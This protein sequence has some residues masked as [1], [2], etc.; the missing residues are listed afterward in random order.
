VAIVAV[1]L[2]GIGTHIKNQ[3][4]SAMEFFHLAVS[5]AVSEDSLDETNGNFDIE[6]FT[7]ESFLLITDERLRVDILKT[8]D[9]LL[10]NK[11]K[12]GKGQKHYKNNNEERMGKIYTGIGENGL[13]FGV[14][15]YADNVYLVLN[16]AKN[17]YIIF[18]IP[19]TVNSYAA[20]FVFGSIVL[21]LCLLYMATIRSIRPLKTLREK[22]KDFAEGNDEI[23]IETR[24]D[25]EIAA[26]INEFDVAVKKM[27]AFRQAR[28]L[29]LRNI[30]HEFKTPITRGKLSL[31]M[32]DSTS[33][34]HKILSKVFI[35]QESLLNEFTRIEQLGT[36]ELKVDKGDYF[37]RDIVDYAL[38]ILGEAAQNVQVD[39]DE[40]KIYADFDLLAT[41][42][43]NLLDNA[44]LYSG[45]K[46]ADITAKNGKM[47]ISNIG[48]PLEFPLDEYKKPFFMQGKKQ[49]ESRGLG[50]GLFISLNIF[51]LHGIETKYEYQEG[52]SIF[53]L[54]F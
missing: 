21:L 8:Y 40:Q 14:V 41:A 49:K 17:E 24:G 32:L 26:V 15:L 10:F 31:E 20:L 50:F 7:N 12:S 2:I 25:D 30:M 44:I 3:R 4:D 54:E 22:I 1:C 19:S 6:K 35:R 46:K 45:D 23:E 43:K 36:G 37:L 51:E 48:K 42:I 39:I 33:P 38:D 53:T 5:M 9:K 29:F 47:T 52:K 11:K 18:Q 28:Q 27:R 16:Q 13:D 34:Y